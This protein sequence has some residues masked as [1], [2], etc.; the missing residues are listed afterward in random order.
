MGLTVEQ[1]APGLQQTEAEVR[2]GL[3]RSA[4]VTA[5]RQADA[6]RFIRENGHQVVAGH[7]DV[8]DSGPDRGRQAGGY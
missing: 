4:A 1:L 8:G 2:A 7:G 3:P 6:G 5:A